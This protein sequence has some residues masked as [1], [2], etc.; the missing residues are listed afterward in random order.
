MSNY[1]INHEKSKRNRTANFLTSSANNAF[2]GE[3]GTVDRDIKILHRVPVVDGK[4]KSPLSGKFINIQTILNTFPE[5]YT[6]IIPRT[7]HGTEYLILP[8]IKT[9]ELHSVNYFKEFDE[10]T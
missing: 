9:T 7:L 4:I 8:M 10:L 5:L 2:S 1:H 6:T 3:N